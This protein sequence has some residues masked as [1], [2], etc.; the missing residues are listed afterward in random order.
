MKNINGKEVNRKGWY[1]MKKTKE[2]KNKEKKKKTKKE[3]KEKITRRRL[4]TR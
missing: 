1:T 4:K 2:E 3:K